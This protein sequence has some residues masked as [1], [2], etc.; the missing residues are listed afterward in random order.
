M[1]AKTVANRDTYVLC[2][3]KWVHYLMLLGFHQHV[4]PSVIDMATGV[5][6]T[7]VPDKL[8]KGVMVRDNQN[9]PKKTKFP[10]TFY[11]TIS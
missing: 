7:T 10:I 11:R 1:N 6:A 8:D 3:N 4:N 5:W 9:V 2:A